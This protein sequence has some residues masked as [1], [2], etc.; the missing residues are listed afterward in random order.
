MRDSATSFALAESVFELAAHLLGEKVEP[1]ADGAAV[2]QKRASRGDMRRQPVELL[3]HVG[4]GR[5]DDGLLVEPVGIERRRGAEERRDLR[6]ELCPDGLGPARRRGFDRSDEPFHRLELPG[7]DARQRPAFGAPRLGERRDGARDAGLER[8]G[9]LGARRRVALV[10]DLDD[11]AHGKQPVDGGRLDAGRQLQAA[12]GIEERGE[13]L[14]VEAHP[15]RG[16]A[17]RD[18]QV[19][20]ALAAGEGLLDL[21]ARILADGVETGRIAQPHVEP[22]AVDGFQLPGPLRRPA[23]PRLAGKPRHARDR[24]DAPPER[25]GP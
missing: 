11:A 12:D 10:L 22:A 25:R 16:R 15:R 17:A 20:L 8:V 2:A 21:P 13:H 4:L 9:K 5:E 6:L 3:A 14:L 19:E 18:R 24:H 7:E 1:A 23:H